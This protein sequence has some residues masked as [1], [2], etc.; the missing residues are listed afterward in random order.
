[1]SSKVRWG[2]LGFAT[3]AREAFIPALLKADNSEFYALA[4]RRPEQLRRCQEHFSR[5]VKVYSD[6]DQLLDDPQV[7]AV[8]VPLPNS[9]HKEWTIKAA[10]KGKHVLCE[11]PLALN[12]QDARQM[13]EECRSHRVQLMEGF[14]YR[15]SDRMRKVREFI[16]ANRLGQVQYI[17]AYFFSLASRASGDRIDPALGGGALL[18]LGC[19]PVNLIGMI[20]GAEPVSIAAAAIPINGVDRLLSAILRYENGLIAN[21]HCGWVNEFRSLGATI[22]GTKA[23][24]AIPEPFWGNA[25]ALSWTTADGRG[26]IAVA[27]TDRFRAEIEDFAAAIRGEHPLLLDAEESIRNLKIIQTILA[28]AGM[29][30]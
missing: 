11:K 9:L 6:Y 30:G 24:L 20:A 10:R 13:V 18:D 23:T 1:M 7:E 17:H 28:K 27:E 5:P 26:E 3:I 19:Y 21:L 16:A 4:S 29:A 12:A 8:Y 15:H 2:I 25:G 14:M 22:M